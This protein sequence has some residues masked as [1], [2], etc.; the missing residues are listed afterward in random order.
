MT[1]PIHPL[2]TRASETALRVVE[3]VKPEL[4]GWL[5]AGT[6]PLAVAAGT[7]LVVLAPA[8][9]VRV[10]CAVFAV[11]AALLFGVS[12]LYHRG[13]WSPRAHRLL[14]RLDHSNIFLII[15]G[16]YTPFTVR[17]L[18]PAG[19]PPAGTGL[20]RCAAGGRLPYA[21]GGCAALALHPGLPGA[22]L[23]RRV[24]P[25]RVPALQRAR[26]AHADPHRGCALQRRG[27]RLRREAPQPVAALVRIPRGLPRAYAG[28][29]R[30]A[31]RRGVHR[32]LHP[33]SE[34]SPLASACWPSP[35]GAPDH[36]AGARD[37]RPGRHVLS[38][39]RGGYYGQEH[40]PERHRPHRRGNAHAGPGKVVRTG[41]LLQHVVHHPAELGSHCQVQ[42][43][44]FADVLLP[45]RRSPSLRPPPHRTLTPSRACVGPQPRRRIRPG[46]RGL[47]G[48]PPAPEVSTVVAQAQLQPP[49]P[50]GDRHEQGAGVDPDAQAA[51]GRDAHGLAAHDELNATP[52]PCSWR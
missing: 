9:R 40:R 35:S 45:R 33:A 25:A 23:G 7:V 18:R 37:L 34:V 8:G 5:H 38:R 44:S 1:D 41:R 49:R 3:T 27:D 24:L 20:G 16:T 50:G 32:D 28:G 11:A 6:F 19:A 31:L 22:G 47:P 21:V 46:R 10:A 30:H 52:A 51:G 39:P 14:Q 17:L 26:G 12:G 13:H 36:G 2:T 15:A 42:N 48:H 29:V 43:R 4:R